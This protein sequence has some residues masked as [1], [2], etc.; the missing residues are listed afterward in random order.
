MPLNTRPLFLVPSLMRQLPH[1]GAVMVDLSDLEGADVT[2]TSA[3]AAANALVD[4]L[5]PLIVEA[6]LAGYEITVIAATSATAT[7]PCLVLNV[8][9]FLVDTAN[10]AWNAVV[11]GV[12]VPLGGSVKAALALRFEPRLAMREAVGDGGSTI[13][14]HY[15]IAFDTP[16]GWLGTVDPSQGGWLVATT[17][18]ATTL[19]D[20]LTAIAGRPGNPGTAATSLLNAS[21]AAATAQWQAHGR[22]ADQLTHCGLAPLFDP[23]TWEVPSGDAGVSLVSAVISDFV[24]DSGT[25]WLPAYGELAGWTLRQLLNRGGGNAG[26]VRGLEEIRARSARS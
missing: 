12:N 26:E 10:E 18:A 3:C 20:G 4:Q 17:P 1:V 8:E 7:A 13:A 25:G 9:A 15:A 2:A 14:S 16:S 6:N 22:Q 24:W 11:T 21:R 5:E 19:P 23:L